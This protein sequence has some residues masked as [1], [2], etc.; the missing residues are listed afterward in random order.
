VTL[1]GDVV[2]DPFFES[3]RLFRYINTDE[4]TLSGFEL[5]AEYDW[6]CYLSPFAVVKY[7]EDATR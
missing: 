4:A 1:A 7:V 3:A 6:N 2:S 5:N